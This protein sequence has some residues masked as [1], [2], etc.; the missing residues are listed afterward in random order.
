[1]KAQI[2][3]ATKIKR[4]LEQYKIA[5]MEKLK[6]VLGTDVRMTVFRKLRELPFRTSY[7]HRGKYYA[8]EK[9]I[10]FDDIGLWSSKSVWFSYYGTLL[11]TT[12]AFVIKSEM[13]YS[14]IE[15]DDILHVSVKESLINLFKKKCI[16]RKKV[17]GVYVYFANSS[18]VQSKQVIRR[19]EYLH[20]Q[21][22][23]L[24]KVEEGLLYHELKATIVL[25]SSLLNEKQKRL[26]A[27]IESVKLGYGGDQII[28]ELLGINCHT[29]AKGRKEIM[30]YDLEIER[31][32]RKGGG[33]SSIKKKSGSRKDD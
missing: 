23:K 1:M 7:S 20:D 3:S 18:D 24:G 5:T 2:Y 16:W 9:T 22:Y 30:D 10:H 12:K 13:G 32:R 4:H 28:S 21:N 26:Y 33:R 8:L 25:F 15:L 11:E 17:A 19:N 31:V 27:G 6:N 29:V 14:V